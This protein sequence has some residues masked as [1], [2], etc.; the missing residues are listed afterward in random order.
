[1]RTRLAAMAD[2][3]QYA[4]FVAEVGGAVVGMAGAF[5]GRIYEEDAPVGRILAL[6]VDKGLRGQNIGSLLLRAAENWVRSQGAAMLLVN[7]GSHREDAHRFYKTA[8]Y[9]LKGLSFAKGLVKR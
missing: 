1:M 2:G 9:A 6:A 5:V 3:E 8:G 7:S 4:T